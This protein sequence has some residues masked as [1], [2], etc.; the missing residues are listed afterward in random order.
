MTEKKGEC[1]LG[2]LE[3]LPEGT[4]FL[5]LNTSFVDPSQYFKD[6][7]PLLRLPAYPES[8]A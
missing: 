3:K 4:I 1:A 7:K 2:S 6:G 8:I 5:A